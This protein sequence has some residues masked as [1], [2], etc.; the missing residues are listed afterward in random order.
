MN[1]WLERENEKNFIVHEWTK[2]YKIVK[3]P[4]Q[5]VP[6]ECKDKNQQDC[7]YP[8]GWNKFIGRCS[9]ITK[10]TYRPGDKDSIEYLGGGQYE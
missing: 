6:N 8:C 5:K 4:H 2:D 10:G 9:G 3:T 7:R 1:R